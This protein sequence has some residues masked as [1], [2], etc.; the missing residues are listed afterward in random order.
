MAKGFGSESAAQSLSEDVGI[1]IDAARHYCRSVLTEWAEL[2]RAARPAR[3]AQCVRILES[4][5]ESNME[6]D[7]KVVVQAVKEIGVLTGLNV[8]NLVVTGTDGMAELQAKIQAQL[9]SQT[10]AASSDDDDDDD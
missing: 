1:S 9:A 6:G 5:I 7:P 3:L 4:V 2:E 10:P 8:K